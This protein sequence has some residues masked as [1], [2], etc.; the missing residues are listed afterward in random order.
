M[1]KQL[2]TM[3]ETQARSLGWENPLE[4]EMATHSSTLAWKIPWMEKRGRLQSMGSQRVGHDWATSLSLSFLIIHIINCANIHRACNV[5]GSLKS[6]EQHTVMW[7]AY[8]SWL[9]NYH[10]CTHHNSWRDITSALTWH[11]LTFRD[12][13][14]LLLLVGWTCILK[15]RREHSSMF[16]ALTR[17]YSVCLEGS[18]SFSEHMQIQVSVTSIWSCDFCFPLQYVLFDCLLYS[19]MKE[20]A[21]L[22]NLLK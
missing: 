13:L 8:C 22:H 19:S 6:A 21:S 3:W 5:L 14:H 1:V 2:P 15:R 9:T 4:K 16:I 18:I 17:F 7:K 20:G 12:Y 11:G 10:I